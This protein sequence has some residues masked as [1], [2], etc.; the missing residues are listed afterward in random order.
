[1]DMYTRDYE[2]GRVF[3]YTLRDLRER[4]PDAFV[5]VERIDIL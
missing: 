2:V 5:W 1:M 4:R 3:S